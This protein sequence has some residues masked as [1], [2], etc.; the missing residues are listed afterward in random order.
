MKSKQIKNFSTFYD[1]MLDYF[2]ARLKH[3]IKGNVMIRYS[4]YIVDK[5]GI[6]INNLDDIAVKGKVRFYQ[7]HDEFYGKG[8]DYVS[9]VVENP[10]WLDVS[11]LANNMIKV[12]GDK[13]HIFLEGVSKKYKNKVYFIIGS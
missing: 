12:T 3:K 4:A 8:K 7:K 13:H 9:K 2:S 6:P 1:Q 10:T 11:K 5:E